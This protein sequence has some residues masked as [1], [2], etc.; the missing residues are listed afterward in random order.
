MTNNIH[1]SCNFHSFSSLIGCF[2]DRFMS[3]SNR[4][5]DPNVPGKNKPEIQ[6][7]SVARGKYSSRLNQNERPSSS[8]TQ[9]SSKSV[10][11]R[12]QQNNQYYRQDPYANGNYSSYYEDEEYYYGQ[13]PSRPARKNPPKKEVKSKEI[14]A[15]IKEPSGS[16]PESVTTKNQPCCLS[17]LFLSLF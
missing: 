6:R 1:Y 12:H 15:K 7:Y 9:G 3:D 2:F 13:Y 17:L 4:R 11:P 8:S 5:T 16:E 14:P 10:N